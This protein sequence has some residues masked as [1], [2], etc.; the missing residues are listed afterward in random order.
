MEVCRG[1]IPEKIQIQIAQVVQLRAQVAYPNKPMLMGLLRWLSNNMEQLLIDKAMT[2]DYQLKSQGVQLFTPAQIREKFATTITITD[3]TTTE[4]QLS[5]A[6][7][8]D[9]AV[10]NDNNSNSNVNNNNNINN[11]SKTK[12]TSFSTTTSHKGTQ[13]K[14]EVLKLVNIG[15]LEANTLTLVLVCERC[16]QQIEITL[17]P[18]ST[19]AIQCSKC[20]SDHIVTLRKEPM[21]EFSF[22]LGYLDI[23]GCSPLEIIHG[24]FRASCLECGESNVLKKLV[25]SG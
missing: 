24:K 8:V 11:N 1:D 17:I 20:S 3:T 22:I 25:F 14:A 12:N 16:H 9:N 4:S 15:I 7:E 19:Y 23:Q 18:L 13:M 5:V 6:D 10:E 2:Q 21:H